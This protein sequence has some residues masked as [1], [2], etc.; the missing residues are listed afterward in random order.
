MGINDAS[1]PLQTPRALP[2]MLVVR[3]DKVPQPQIA[4]WNF[5]SYCV[6]MLIDRLMDRSGGFRRDYT[7][8]WSVF[9]A[10]I[11][12]RAYIDK[13]TSLR[14]LACGCGLSDICTLD[15]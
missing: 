7:V 5:F 9:D 15:Q 4:Y 13:V 8:N 14:C 10:F 2:L 3:E 12:L 6:L 11:Q 1:W